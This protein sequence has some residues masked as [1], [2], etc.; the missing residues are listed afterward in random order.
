MVHT[1]KKSLIHSRICLVIQTR[2]NDFTGHPVN[3]MAHAASSV[4]VHPKII[5]TGHA[6]EHRT[7]CMDRMST[8][9]VTFFAP[10]HTINRLAPVIA[11]LRASGCLVKSGVSSGHL[12][13][14]KIIGLQ[15]AVRVN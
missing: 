6:L 10:I 1:G 3:L 14:V 13:I 7:A 5:M 4:V 2:K 12:T 11:L 8:A 15:V 9:S